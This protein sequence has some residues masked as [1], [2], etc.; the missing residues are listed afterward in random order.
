MSGPKFKKR[1]ASNRNFH[2]M[3][4]NAFSKSISKSNP[5][6]FLSWVYCRTS[7]ITRVF[8]PINLPFDFHE[9]ENLK[10][11]LFCLRYRNRLFY[12]RHSK[13]IL[14][15]SFWEILW[16]HL[17]L[18]LYLLHLVSE[19]M[20]VHL[21]EIQG[22]VIWEESFQCLSKKKPLKFCNETV[23]TFIIFHVFKCW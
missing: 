15:A 2:E 8:S 19:L 4:S 18:E 13:G 6:I 5:G 11:F 7:Y 17:S 21:F 16:V 23:W 9:V 3:E 20:K 22:Y 10:Q 14:V 12:K 1:K